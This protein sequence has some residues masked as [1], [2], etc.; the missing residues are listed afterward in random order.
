MTHVS[1][2]IQS[3]VI[4]SCNIFVYFHLHVF[5]RFFVGDMDYGGNGSRSKKQRM[6]RRITH[7]SYHNLVTGILLFFLN[8][9][10]F[11][12]CLHVRT[13]PRGFCVGVNFVWCFY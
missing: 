7:P 8:A 12:P 9:E 3:S 11:P 6:I 13:F 4:L 5:S 2:S 1:F 10:I